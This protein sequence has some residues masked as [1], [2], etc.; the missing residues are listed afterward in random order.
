MA[1]VAL[2]AYDVQTVFGEAG[3][4][5][6]FITQ[7]ANLLRSAGEMVTIVMTR[8]ESTPV[9]VDPEWR[10]RYQRNGI[11]LIEMQIPAPLSTHWHDMPTLGLSEMV[12][13]IIQ[14]FDIAY[15]QDWGNASFH[16]VRQRRYSRDPSPI[17]VTVLH[18]PS[19]WR[20]S[21]E[22]K[23]PDLPKDLHLAY[24]ERYAAKHCDFVVSP[25]CFMR[26]HL[27]HLGW[28]FPSQ[29]DVLGLPMLDQNI[30]TPVPG[31]SDI[32]KIVYLGSVE[33][34]G[35]IQIFTAALQHLAKTETSRI[36]VL[37]LGTAPDSKLLQASLRAITHAGYSVSHKPLVT[38]SDI[39]KSLGNNAPEI[40]CV[41]PSASGNLYGP[42]QAC[43]IPGLKVIAPSSGGM[44][45]IVNGADQFV[46]PSPVDLAAKI[47]A[48]LKNRPASAGVEAYDCEAANSR[49]LTFHR[50]AVSVCP[51]QRLHSQSSPSVDIC[52]THN[53]TGG[54]VNGACG[55]SGDL[56]LFIDAG[57]VPA[58]HALERMRDAITISGDDCLICGSYVFSGAKP[59]FD[60]DTGEVTV[61][62]HAVNIPLGM[63][64]AGGILNPSVFGGSM[65]MVRRS[66]FE[67]V[68]GFRE[69]RGAGPEHWEF[70]LRL[71]FGG[72]RIDVLPEVLHYSRQVE[73]KPVPDIASDSYCK[74]LVA[75]Y[76]EALATVGLEGAA[77]ALSG[78]YQKNREM[79]ARIEYLNA[80]LK[81]RDPASRY[82]F[83][84]KRGDGFR[85]TSLI[86]WLRQRYREMLPLETRLNIHRKFFAPFVG[87]YKPP[88]PLTPPTQ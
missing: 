88:G 35:G 87:P 74:H 77:L 11:S 21:A 64:L 86:E 14:G 6:T 69:F 42:I 4:V 9:R 73:D 34:S 29:V 49:W 22:A 72:Y 67:K 79:K 70:Y 59:P 32:R 63:D 65:F 52:V 20:L 48:R 36:P 78:F 54:I 10:A 7:W 76:E 61:P 2:V 33:Q 85:R 71:V 24:Q 80:K 60:P 28:E 51:N 1:K 5:G 37:L 50:K 27:E 44:P 81:R 75:T 66:V 55:G 30:G 12:A 8:T 18:G 43:L 39:R 62:P 17:C 58:L 26:E 56:I 38:G 45:E 46:Y 41:I 3:Q 16:L 83:F 19:E 84:S 13:P 23:Y 82:I 31:T 68:G 15:F 57:D 47:A 25:T 40:L 53:R